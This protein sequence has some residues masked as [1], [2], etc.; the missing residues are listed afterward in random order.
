MLQ[1]ILGSGKKKFMVEVNTALT[2]RVADLAR[3]EL[4]D[5]E[6]ETFTHQL[7]DILKYI[8]QL[9]KVETTGVEPLTHP[10]E[11]SVFLRPDEARH[12]PRDGQGKPKVLGSAPD[13]LYD[14]FKVP[15][16]L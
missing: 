10:L 5:L 7:G 1:A 14:G 12:F 9:Q 4:S 13:V 16:I 6:V 15:Q 8:E 11:L 2:R 3:L